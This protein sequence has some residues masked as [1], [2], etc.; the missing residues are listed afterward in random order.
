MA[1]VHGT[2]NNFKV[3]SLDLRF[4]DRKNLVD[5]ISGRNL[6]TFSRD[7]I[8][9]YV[10]E[11]GVI[12]SAAVDEARFDHDIDGNSLGLLIEESRTNSL[13]YSEGPNW[14]ITGAT[15]SIS[16]NAA[17]APDGNFTSI[18]VFG[19]YTDFVS[20]PT[21]PSN[22]GGAW[23][24][25]YDLVA[26]TTDKSQTMIGGYDSTQHTPRIEEYP[27]GWFR[28]I[29]EARAFN[30]NPVYCFSLFV[31]PNGATTVKTR[32]NVDQVELYV[33][34]TS[35]TGVY[36]WGSQLELVKDFPTSYIPTPA[37]FT[38]RSTTATYYDANGIIQTAAIDV[39]RDNAYFPDENGVMQPA[40]LLLEEASTNL[41]AQSTTLTTYATSNAT[42]PGQT[43]TAPD[44]SLSTVK[45]L[46]EN[47]NTSTH[48][49]IRSYGA[50]YDTWRWSFFVKPNGRT[51]FRI[52]TIDGSG[53]LVRFTLSGDG[54]A[55][56]ISG[57]SSASIEK[58]PNGWYKCSYVASFVATLTNPRIVLYNGAQSYVGDG[59]GIYV[60]G[61]QFENQ[62]TFGTSYIPTTPTFTSRAST[63]TYYDSNG[64]VQT[65]A[66]D[67]ARDDAYFPDENGVMTSAGLLLE[68]AG[69]NDN[70]H[71]EHVNLYSTTELTTRENQE[72]APDLSFTAGTIIETT[73]NSYHKL[74]L[75]PTPATGNLT[76]SAF[77]KNKQGN[78][79]ALLTFNDGGNDLGFYFNP[80]SGSVVGVLTGAGTTTPLDYGVQKLANDWY[81]IHVSGIATA[82]SGQSA[83]YVIDNT[84]NSTH[85]GTGTDGFYVWGFQM[86]QN[87]YPSSYIETPPSFFSRSQTNADSASF[88]Q[89]DGTIGYA[90][91]DVVRDN[92]YFPDENG[93]FYP[94]GTLLEPEIENLMPYSEDFNS[95]STKTNISVS[96]DTA[97][98]NAPDGTQTADKITNTANETGL[99]N[100]ISS[101]T[102]THTVSVYVKYSG[103]TNWARMTS[104]IGNP[105]AW[106]DINNGNVG[107]QSNGAVGRIQP[108][109]NGWYRCIM[110]A[111]F[112]GV[113]VF[114]IMPSS[115]NGSTVEGNGN[116]LY[117]WGCQI[118]AN[119][120]DTSYIPTTSSTATRG[121]DFVNS[122]SSTTRSA[123]NSTSSTV[124]RNA[125]DAIIS[126]SEFS[127]FYNLTEGSFFVNGGPKQIDSSSAQVLFSADSGSDTHRTQVHVGISTS[128]VKLRVENGGVL[129]V[130][131][132]ISG[133]T[134]AGNN[135]SKISARY[136]TNDFR[137]DCQNLNGIDTSGT[138]STSLTQFNIGSRYS[139][140]QD[141]LN[142]HI[143]R[144]TYWTNKL[145]DSQLERITQ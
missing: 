77:I 40:G 2:N 104:G 91:T 116:S 101:I 137:I 37:T 54:T 89:S 93:T 36:F 52:Y 70:P 47:T 126:G 33:D 120:Y 11:N 28:I 22:V 5:T 38:S 145:S 14:T 30:G 9:T 80:S 20:L 66:I 18:R 143:K 48:H 92:V 74:F 10:D 81:R 1:V 83:L 16:F 19:E 84:T 141:H 72:L 43:I 130:N 112:S 78:R 85:V 115:A 73:A 29:D 12:Q 97:E 108:V 139:P 103:T 132:T 95:W 32:I 42:L 100:T 55:T 107:T 44:G 121:R 34:G 8:G 90:S 6:I 129:Q 4:S 86:E 131:T 3:P 123:D 25:E 138:P 13:T 94:A 88:Y 41:E 17:I 64:V 61:L 71:S 53:G 56:P 63:A 27:N 68:G 142:G 49:I 51:K 7:S 118:E 79:N 45:L 102:G 65:A 109:G 114:A 122:G 134:V 106:F 26:Q 111:N 15:G 24:V 99:A 46:T 140:A 62:V 58:Y 105:Q 82:S 23:I 124:T 135:D 144:L 75:N 39:A 21:F 76:L 69:T 119:S 60:W 98:T 67:E 35:T 31:K 110:T 125:D 57:A 136:G 117:V 96:T 59:S 127:S 113:T 87:S 128:A 50:N 133:T